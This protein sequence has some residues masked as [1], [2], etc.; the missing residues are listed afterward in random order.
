MI[1]WFETGFLTLSL[2]WHRNF[3]FKL[4]F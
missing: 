1:I 2:V 4:R 3:G